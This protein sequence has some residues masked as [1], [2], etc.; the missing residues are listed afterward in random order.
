[1]DPKSIADQYPA[2]AKRPD[3]R[4]AVELT[5]KYLLGTVEM[6]I[7]HTFITYKVFDAIPDDGDISLTDLAEKVGGEQE[8]L[9]R[10]SNYLVSADI[11]SSPGPNRV[12]HGQ[13]SRH[14]R[15]TEV[16]AGL[17]VHSFNM[18]FRPMAQLPV[19]FEKHGLASPKTAKVTPFGL[20]WGYP[21]W[22]VYDILD[23]EP[24][25]ARFFHGFLARSAQVYDLKS[26]YDLAWMQGPLSASASEG[27]TRPAIVDIGGSSGL[28]LRDM[29]ADNSF[30]PAER[31]ALL[32]LPK[33][34]EN[35][36]DNLDEGLRSIQLVGGSILEP[37]PE[38]LHGA[39]LYHFRRILNDLPDE[40]VVTA[41]KNVQAAA[42]P[43]TRIVIIEELLS[44]EKAPL[45]VGFDLFV[46]LVGGKRR[47]ARM[48]NELA[49]RAGFRL[50]A[51]FHDKASNFGVLE[52]EVV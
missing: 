5:G 41:F 31:C 18:L 15:S 50:S 27:A 24:K 1:M 4:I 7:L 26:V 48:Y 52:F 35:T 10:F 6:G 21:D 8:I 23:A 38:K 34:I 19:F 12:A 9:E 42:R 16:A 33:A 40:D 43:D 30:I 51:Q 13:T 25:L 32:D 37:V 44:S 20:A 14:Y 46:M 2:S 17:L 29:L 22:D 39:V 11:L 28:A 3:I 36:R 45:A 49:A 47:N